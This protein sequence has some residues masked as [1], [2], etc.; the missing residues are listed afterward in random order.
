MQEE[1]GG[2]VVAIT[3]EENL[4]LSGNSVIDLI[5][6]A[7]LYARV[8]LVRGPDQ[9]YLLMELELIEPSIYLRMHKNAPQRFA[10]A[11]KRAIVG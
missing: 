8:D 9:G 11:L 5:N 6:P 1:H 2:T 10:H 7:P 3:P 4:R